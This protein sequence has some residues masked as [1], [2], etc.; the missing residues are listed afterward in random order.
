MHWRWKLK[1]TYYFLRLLTFLRRSLCCLPQ[2]LHTHSFIL[3]FELKHLSM[4][5]APMQMF[6]AHDSISPQFQ[7]NLMGHLLLQLSL[8]LRQP[9]IQRLLVNCTHCMIGTFITGAVKPIEERISSLKDTLKKNKFLAAHLLMQRWLKHSV[10][11]DESNWWLLTKRR[12]A[13]K[14]RAWWQSRQTQAAV[15]NLE[16]RAASIKSSRRLHDCRP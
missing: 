1:N 6:F 5:V 10:I 16:P 11:A 14:G 3:P 15:W 12:Q 4:D 9:L 7:Q 13:S 2:K 8:Q